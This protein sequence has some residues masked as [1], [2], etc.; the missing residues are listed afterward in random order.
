MEGQ[1]IQWLNDKRQKSPSIHYTVNNTY[2][3]L[4]KT[5]DELLIW[6][7]RFI[8]QEIKLDGYVNILQLIRY[9]RAYGQYSDVF[10]FI[11]I[12]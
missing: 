1:T 5:S 6:Q 2:T 9:S 7:L 11:C 4:T 8:I 10:H 3:T 12:C